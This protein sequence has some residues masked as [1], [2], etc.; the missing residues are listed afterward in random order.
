MKYDFFDDCRDILTLFKQAQFSE[1]E[2]IFLPGTG[3]CYMPGDK[4][5]WRTMAYNYSPDFVV[6]K[7]TGTPGLHFFSDGVYQGKIGMICKDMVDGLD[8]YS[9]NGLKIN[10]HGPE[11]LENYYNTVIKKESEIRWLR[12]EYLR[13]ESAIDYVLDDLAA[14]SIE[15]QKLCEARQC[16]INFYGRC[17]TNCHE[18]TSKYYSGN[19]YL[20]P[21]MMYGCILELAHRDDKL[22]LEMSFINAAY[23]YA[24]LVDLEKLF[25]FNK[26]PG[27]DKIWARKIDYEIRFFGAMQNNQSF[28]CSN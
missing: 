7:T 6:V 15:Y 13:A 1:G 25:E 20:T 14:V 21:E 8:V 19:F 18:S 4:V 11:E 23:G 22:L 27:D 24:K 16:L 17:L 2:I 28:H 9:V 12:K 5:P 26:T 3:H 10:I